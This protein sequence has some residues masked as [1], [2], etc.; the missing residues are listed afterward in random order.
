M[1]RRIAAMTLFVAWI[2]L[3]CGVAGAEPP[4]GGTVLGT[5]EV[6]VKVQPTV[7]RMEMT[8]Q[9]Q[10]KTLEGALKKLKDGRAVATAKLQELKAQKDSIR[11]STPVAIKVGPATPTYTYPT[12]V[13]PAGPAGDAG[14]Y[15]APGVAVPELPP[16]TVPPPVIEPA[17]EGATLPRPAIPPT[18]E[19]VPSAAPAVPPTAAPAWRAAGT[20][21]SA[22]GWGCYIVSAT[23]AADW[24]LAGDSP[25]ALLTA[26]EKL[27]EKI[28]AADLA[29]VKPAASRGDDREP[30][31]GP[32]PP[33]DP[34]GTPPYQVPPACPGPAPG[35][36]PACYVPAGAAAPGMP[37]FAYAARLTE[38]QRKAALAEACAKAKTQ[39]KELAEAAGVKLGGIASLSRNINTLARAE[40][41]DANVC[42]PPVPAHAFGLGDDEGLSHTPAEIGFIIIVSAQFRLE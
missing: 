37:R 4:G 24:P 18:L 20:T 8:L 33:F 42:Y 35:A 22:P 28:L 7:L 3:C 17:P 27:Q 40:G 13:P 1:L 39:A 10:D 34:Y 14:R 16:P 5:G 2:A 36:G 6:T 30:E 26:A 38:G 23:I 25:E 12:P 21:P 31:E 41:L 11:S 15:G 9:F 19:S 29:G 32:S